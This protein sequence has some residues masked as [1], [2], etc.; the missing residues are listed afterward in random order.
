MSKYRYEVKST[1]RISESNM[2][3]TQKFLNMA[4]TSEEFFLMKY[5]RKHTELKH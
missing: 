4:K 2:K 1:E 3:K 5:I